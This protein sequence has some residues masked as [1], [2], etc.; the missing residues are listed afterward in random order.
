MSAVTEKDIVAMLDK[1]DEDQKGACNSLGN[2]LLQTG[3]HLNAHAL[4]IL[5]HSL[6]SM[7][8]IRRGLET[9][10]DAVHK[11]QDEG[12]SESDGVSDAAQ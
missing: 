6:Q 1:V 9:V 7:A 8:N 11:M 2:I 10:C 3:D 5:A 12:K 4:E